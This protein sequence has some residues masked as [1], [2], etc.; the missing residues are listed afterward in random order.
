MTACGREVMDV[1]QTQLRQVVGYVE[2]DIKDAL[3]EM[4]LANRRVSESALIDRALQI[5]MPQLVKEYLPSS[6]RP[7]HGRKALAG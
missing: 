5:A 2:A 4:K 3:N 6:K 7:R 1:A